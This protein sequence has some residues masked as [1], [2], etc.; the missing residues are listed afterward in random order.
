MTDERVS[1]PEDRLVEI[2]QTEDEKTKIGEKNKTRASGT[3]RTMLNI[4][5]FIQLSL[6]RKKKRRIQKKNLAKIMAEISS[7]LVKT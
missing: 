1:E 7:Y 3:C 2:I 6:T 5:S 4:L